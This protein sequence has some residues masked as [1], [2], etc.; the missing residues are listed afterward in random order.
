MGGKGNGNPIH[1]CYGHGLLLPGATCQ[2][3]LFLEQ[4]F[5]TVARRCASGDRECLLHRLL[6]PRKQEKPCSRGKM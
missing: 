6:R 4:P 5:Q 1:P 3:S 2:V